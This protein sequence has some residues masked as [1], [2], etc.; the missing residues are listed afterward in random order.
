MS[1]TF[2]QAEQVVRDLLPWAGLDAAALAARTE[3]LPM[4]VYL[5]DAQ[6]YVTHFNPACVQFS[7]RT[8]VLGVDRWCVTW[9]LFTDDGKPLPH[10]ACPMAEAILTQRAVRGPFAVALRPD[11]FQRAFVP[12]PTPIFD[13]GTLVGALNAFVDVTDRLPIAVLYRRAQRCRQ[14]AAEADPEAYGLLTTLA[15]TYEWELIQRDEH[16]RGAPEK[17]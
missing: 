2:D 14:L 16:K 10:E 12:L 8:P 3:P 1:V 7:G 9:R 5:T 15:M 4:P 13:R 6:G 11:G 17:L